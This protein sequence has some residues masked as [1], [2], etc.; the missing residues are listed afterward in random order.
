MTGLTARWNGR[1]PRSIRPCPC[2]E[3][4]RSV[5]AL[6]LEQNRPYKEAIRRALA[7]LALPGHARLA[8]ACTAR[9]VD[10]IWHAAGDHSADFSWYTKRAILAAVYGFN[11][12]ST[13]CATPARMMPRRWRFLD[14][15]LAGVGG[16]ARC[17]AGRRRRGRLRPAT[18]PMTAYR[19][20]PMPDRYANYTRLTFDR[21]HPRVLRITMGGGQ[22]RPNP[23]DAV[24]HRELGDVWRDIDADPD[25]NSVIITGAGRA[26]SAGG[27]FAMIEQIMADFETRARVWKEA[28]D[29]VY[30]IINC[31]SRWSARC[32]DRQWAQAWCVACSL[33]CRSPPRTRA[34]LTA[35]RGLAS[36][37]AIIR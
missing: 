5:I 27:D 10:A 21:P 13:G 23:V 22:E 25:V 19:R 24:M 34:S 26:F 31:G 7:Q 36:P 1:L 18:N 9:T 33:T 29:L 17:A 16:S 12:C 20:R 28:R 32:A 11:R 30:N 14:R 4:V 37:R 3:R 2:T 15:R 35:T 6:R 8:A